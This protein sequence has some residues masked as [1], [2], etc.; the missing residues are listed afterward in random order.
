MRGWGGRREWMLFC[1]C[2]IRLPVRLS[3]IQL[4]YTQH[5]VS[6]PLC[7]YRSMPESNPVALHSFE[8]IYDAQSPSFAVGKRE[9][10]TGTYV[11]WTRDDLKTLK[12]GDRFAFFY[13]TLSNLN[14]LSRLSMPNWHWQVTQRQLTVESLKKCAPRRLSPKSASVNV[15]FGWTLEEKMIDFQDLIKHLLICLQNCGN[16]WNH[17][18]FQRCESGRRVLVGRK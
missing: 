12:R 5:L 1:K 9:D 4:N 18:H 11:T 6:T 10:K 16:K 7:P 2:S 3:G 14:W 13:L 8:V 15:H 17:H